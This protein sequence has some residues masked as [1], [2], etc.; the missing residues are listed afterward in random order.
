VT[1]W[2]WVAEFPA[3]P[4]AIPA[5]AATE[6]DDKG[7]LSQV[8]QLSQGVAGEQV[9]HEGGQVSQ[10]SQLSQPFGD[11][12]AYRDDDAREAFEE[13]AAIMEFDGG[14]TRAEAE[15]AAAANKI[16]ANIVPAEPVRWPF[17]EWGDLR[18]CLLCR[19]LSPGGRCLAAWRGELRAARDWGPTLPG[20]PQRCIGYDPKADDPDQRPG[21]ERWPEM[22]VWQARATTEAKFAP[23]D[24]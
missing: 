3:Q 8:S 21:R 2:A 1:L 16:G 24:L 20:Q 10:V 18:P 7:A 15:Q 19:N 22:I 23:S 11:A 5:T 9:R 14:M 4:V 17:E 12:G 6:Q 13:R